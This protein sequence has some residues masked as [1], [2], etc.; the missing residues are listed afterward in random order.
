MPDKKIADQHHATFE[1]IRH[2]DAD[3]NEYWLARE[4]ADVLDY[5]QY[6][7]FLPVVERAK[8][9]CRNSGHPVRDHI[10]DYLTMVDADAGSKH[11]ADRKRQEEA[12]EEVTTNH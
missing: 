1:N 5:S 9:A 6:R 12:G 11:Q 2:V 7:H 10:E 3:G 8:E 4:L